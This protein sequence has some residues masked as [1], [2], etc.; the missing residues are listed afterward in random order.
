MTAGRLFPSVHAASNVSAMVLPLCLQCSEG[1]GTCLAT[2]TRAERFHIVLSLRE[3]C[4]ATDYAI[5]SLRGF[6]FAGKSSW[7]VAT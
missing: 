3:S 1:D 7:P 4:F 5:C 2:S 6:R